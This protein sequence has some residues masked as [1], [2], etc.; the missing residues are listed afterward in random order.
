MLKVWT[1][2][3]GAHRGSDG[4]DITVKSGDKVFAPTWSMVMDY[5]ACKITDAQYTDAYL[6]MMR[7][8]YFECRGRWDELLAMDEVTLLCYCKAGLFCHRTLLA[9]ILVKLGATYLGER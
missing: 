8:S 3:V 4:L 6:A 9:G 7:Q 2:R 1:G 5:K